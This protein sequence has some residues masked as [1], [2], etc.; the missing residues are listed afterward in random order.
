MAANERSGYFFS[1]KTRPADIAASEQAGPTPPMKGGTINGRR[2]ISAACCPRCQSHSVYWRL[3]ISIY[4]LF[5]EFI[6]SRATLNAEFLVKSPKKHSKKGQCC[7][8]WVEGGNRTR[9]SNFYA[10][11]YTKNNWTQSI[12]SSIANFISTISIELELRSTIDWT[13]HSL[14]RL[15][16]MTE[17]GEGARK[18]SV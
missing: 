4:D 9:V 3:S 8:F 13:H 17:S 11:F 18:P 15:V 2:R 14:A 6:T 7:K 1:I 5:S 10:K 16:G 12:A